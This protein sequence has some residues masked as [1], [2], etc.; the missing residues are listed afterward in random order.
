MRTVGLIGG[1]SWESTV[2]YY[3]IINE[4]IKERLG[5]L[6]S[7]KILLSS[8][9]FQEIADLQAAGNWAGIAETLSNTALALEAAGADIILICTNTMHKIS[10]DIEAAIQV[11]LLH[12]ADV[13]ALEAKKIGVDKV[14]LLGTRFT[15]EQNFYTERLKNSGLDV[16]V[17]V[18]VDRDSI[19]RIIFEE[20]CLGIL[21]ESSRQQFRE[22]IYRLA[23]NGAKAVILGCTE[24]GLLVGSDDSCLPLLDTTLIHAKSAAEWAVS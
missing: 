22:I 8:V 18:E 6:N 11:P 3:R 9:N 7:A 15:M 1:L 2:S 13:T 23:D 19:H 16:V 20:L 14:G 5:G 17:P 24:I 12:I 4:S 10:P 21:T